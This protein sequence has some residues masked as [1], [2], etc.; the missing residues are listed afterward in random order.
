MNKIAS[1]KILVDFTK[2]KKGTQYDDH[3]VLALADGTNIGFEAKVVDTLPDTG[4]G[5]YIYLVPKTGSTGDT[6]D[7]YI[8]ALEED[9]SYGWEHIGSTDIT[10]EVDNELS[11]TSENPVQNKVITQAIGNVE[12]ILHTLNNGEES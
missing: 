9:G 6:Y 1:K 12:Q 11:D 5:G 4:E 10:I 3:F 2:A 7:E 8:W